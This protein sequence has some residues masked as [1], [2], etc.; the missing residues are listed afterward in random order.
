MTTTVDEVIKSAA[1]VA[2]DAAEGRLDPAALDAA[3]TAECR[4]L[5]GTVGGPEDA[6]WTV[7]LDV[8]RQVLALG[9]VPADE[10]GEWLALARRRSQSANGPV[11][12]SAAVEVRGLPVMADDGDTSAAGT[13]SPGSDASG[14]GLDP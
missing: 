8:A 2:R 10:L 9:G 1:A 11:E 5:F 3:V 12:R 13:L 7:H 4:A 14:D 6:L